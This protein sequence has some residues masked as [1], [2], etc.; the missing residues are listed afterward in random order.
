LNG[1]NGWL[2]WRWIFLIEGVMPIVFGLLLFV[3]LPST[4]E[5]A[6]FGFSQADKDLAVKRSR[7]AHNPKD[8]KLRPQ[9]ILP[10]LLNP[11]FWFLNFIFGAYHYCNSPITNFIQQIVQARSPF[12]YIGSIW[13]V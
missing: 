4:P 7:R 6:R 10:V 9:K 3:F 5:K 12:I 1:K 8:A 2:A 11:V 13:Q